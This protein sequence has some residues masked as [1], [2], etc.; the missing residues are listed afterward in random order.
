MIHWRLSIAFIALVFATFFCCATV[1]AQQSL[2]DEALLRL[3]TDI[4]VLLE[5]RYAAAQDSDE[6]FPGATVALGLPDRRFARFVIGF[7]DINKKSPMLSG[8]R[9]PSGSIGKTYVAAVVLSLAADGLLDLND[10]IQEWLGDEPWF[11]R[12]PNGNS[13]TVRQLLNHS[14]GLIDHVFDSGSQFQAYFRRQ[15]ALGSAGGSIDPRDLINFILDRDPLFTAGD[16]FHYSDTNYIIL[17]M[18][19]EAASGSSYYEVLRERFLEPLHLDHTSALDHR[20]IPGIVQGYAVAGQALFGL[21]PEVVVDGELVFDPLIEW[22]GGGL[23]STSEDLVRWAMALFTG[24]EVTSQSLHEMLNSIAVP[25]YHPSV[26]G[27]AYGYGLGMYIA[28]TEHGTAYRHGGFFPGYNSFLA[29]Y[30]EYGFA[31]AMQINADRTGIEDHVKA[32]T[33]TVIRALPEVAV[34]AGAAR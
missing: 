6:L 24:E 32:I 31:V 13:I 9:M 15:M 11:D 16:G 27:Q 30:P 12:L 20:K 28:R 22:T 4:G 26:S 10:S 3:K 14:S 2:S 19:I 17:G 7:A 23:I 1:S 29:Y 33:D 21:P 5:T 25:A 8:S 18:I 34:P